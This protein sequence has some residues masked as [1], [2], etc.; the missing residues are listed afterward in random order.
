[1]DILNEFL[2]YFSDVGST[3]R[4]V[5]AGTVLLGI[6]SG[7]LGTF[8]VLRRQSLL[9]DAMAHAALPGICIA[10]L[11]TGQKHPLWI[12]LGAS[13]TGLLG[14]MLIPWIT[15]RSKIKTDAAMGIILSVF[16]GIGIFL[17]TMIQKSNMGS[18]A[19]LDHFLFGKAASLTQEDVTAIGFLCIVMVV[20][21]LL[22]YKQFQILCF[23]PAFG[24]SLGLNIRF[25]DI[26]LIAMIVIAVMLGLQS[27]GVVLMVAMLIL[28]ASSARQWTNSLGIML[29]LSGG[30]GAIAGIIGAFCST[31]APKVPTGPVMVLSSS[32]LLFFSLSF[33]PSQG[34][35]PKLWKRRQQKSHREEEHLLK[36]IYKEYE[37][38]KTFPIPLEYRSSLETKIEQNI[39][40]CGAKKLN[41]LIQKGLLVWQGNFIQL[42]D[43][44]M[45]KARILLRKHRLWELYLQRK[46]DIASDH[47]HR[48]ADDIEH[49]LPLEVVEELDKVLGSPQSDPHGRPIPAMHKEARP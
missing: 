44:G 19:G 28:P 46:M 40:F 47:V 11:I 18:Q 29:I 33:A 14:A 13:L 10:F 32:F 20:S 37:K 8:A 38:A 45:E 12:M 49:I 30:L 42:S 34:I 26:L 35:L 27:V 39:L 1:M 9:G 24:K 36:D 6:L 41:R 2:I 5:M 22:F 4:I 3:R 16:F 43:K 15:S 25:F 23:D 21:V 31:L 7:V 17:L 48:D